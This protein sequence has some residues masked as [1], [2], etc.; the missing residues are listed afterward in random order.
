MFTCKKCN[1]GY[2]AR[3][4]LW[5]HE[6]K[7]KDPEEIID[8]NDEINKLDNEPVDK[9][10][11][12]LMLIKQNTELIKETSD[13]KNMMLE[14]CKNGTH[15]TTNNNNTHTNSHNKAFN[16][17]FFLNE[18][19][20][21]ALNIQDF[22]SSIK[23]SIDDLEN[24]GRR[25]YIEGISNIILKGLNKLEQHFRP[26][27]CSDQK[28]EILYIKDD[29]QWTKD[30]EQKTHLTKAIRQVVGKNIKQ[31]SEWQKMYP[32]FNNPDSKQNDK[33]LKIVCESMSGGTKEE[34]NKNYNKI[35]KNIAKETIIDKMSL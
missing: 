32:E 17:N 33:Y 4:S 22:V 2:N 11:L 34:T 35:I 12:I 5:Y 19:C 6:K 26:I 18:T 25:G 27:H 28:R 1:K 23:P 29:N 13:F 31:I 30:D 15:N 9:D 10:Q 16:L 14:V 21:D 24:T 8:I 20:K 3:N 7:C